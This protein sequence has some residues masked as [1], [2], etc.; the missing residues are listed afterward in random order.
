MKTVWKPY[1]LPV[2]YKQGH[3]Y[4]LNPPM[5]FI[6]SLKRMQ[7]SI[8]TPIS[9]SIFEFLFENW[10]G[11]VKDI[12]HTCSSANV[13]PVKGKIRQDSDRLERTANK[14]LV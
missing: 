5:L 14:A 10:P 8:N 11:N 13:L 7:G 1:F 9:Y 2:K 6:Y 4:L 3:I 12:I